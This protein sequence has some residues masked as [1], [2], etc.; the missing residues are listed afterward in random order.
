MPQIRPSWPSG[1]LW[2][3]LATDDIR[4]ETP[5]PAC[6]CPAAT[7]FK[8]TAVG[9]WFCPEVPNE[10]ARVKLWAMLKRS[11]GIP[12]PRRFLG[13]SSEALRV[14]ASA[15]VAEFEAQLE[16]L[17]NDDPNF[18][19]LKPILL[20]VM[21][22]S[23]LRTLS[24][25]LTEARTLLAAERERARA[26]TWRDTDP[27]PPRLR[28]RPT[29]TE[30]LGLDEMVQADRRYT[31]VKQA[32]NVNQANEPKPKKEPPPLIRKRRYDFED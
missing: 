5:C 26:K 17:Q 25:N 19:E 13:S 10:E 6:R 24:E 21:A 12:D 14:V 28:R 29:L 2:R 15:A 11:P 20:R 3:R 7:H 9:V 22:R 16:Q 23:P 27:E 18:A 8:D 30:E 1:D 32:P 4:D 31:G